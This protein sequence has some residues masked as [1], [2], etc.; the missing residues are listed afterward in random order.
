MAESLRATVGQFSSSAGRWQPRAANV[1]AVEPAADHPRAER[2][3]LYLL[4]EVTGAGGGNAALYR[5]MLNAAQTAYYE[6]GEA[7][8]VALRQSVREVQAILRRANEA[9]PEA[10]WRAGMTMVVRYGNHLIIGQAGPALL[11]VSHPKTVNVYPEKPGDSGPALGGAERPEVF[12]YDTTLEPSSIVLLAQSNWTGQVRLEA[13]AV[14]AAAANVNAATQ[15]LGQL[16]GKADLTALLIGFDYDIPSVREES[17]GIKPLPAGGPTGVV[18]AAEAESEPPKPQGKGLFAGLFAKKA[19][20]DR[21]EPAAEEAIAPEPEEEFAEPEDLLPPAR[22]VTTAPPVAPPPARPAEPPP[23]PEEWKAAVAREERMAMPPP[24][25]VPAAAAA[26]AAP[27]APPLP[28]PEETY[29]PEPVVPVPPP[30]RRRSAWALV[31]AVVLIPLLIV[32]V[33]VAM[34]YVRTE[35]ADKQF[36]DRRGRRAGRHH[37]G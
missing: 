34:L 26:V 36:A 32:G 1:R 4:I 19:V 16:A 30:P 9:L 2:G 20:A 17:A 12:I 15:Y 29:E 33:I 27:V 24:L 3:S 8:E 37:P 22:A 28:V 35:A 10:Q 11:L 18:A 7:V 14:A 13:L 23:S 21:A 25:A 31:V 5:Q 6:I